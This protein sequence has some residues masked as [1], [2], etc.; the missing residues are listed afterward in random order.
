MDDFHRG[1]LL[2]SMIHYNMD[3]GVCQYFFKIFLSR[4]RLPALTY[5]GQ[6]GC[7]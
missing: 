2:D 1:V 3:S 7:A 4:A 6:T 5:R